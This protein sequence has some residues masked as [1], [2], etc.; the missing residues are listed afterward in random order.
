MTH[1]PENHRK[2]GKESNWMTHIFG[3]HRKNGKESN[4]ITYIPGTG[5]ELLTERQQREASRRGYGDAPFARPA[6]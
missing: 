4:W 6:K 3:N 1:I 2:N 5:A